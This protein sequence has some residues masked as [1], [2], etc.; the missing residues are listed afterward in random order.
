MSAAKVIPSTGKNPPK[1]M[2]TMIESSSETTK[3]WSDLIRG[4][5]LISAKIGD[6]DKINFTGVQNAGARIYCSLMSPAAIEKYNGG[7]LLGQFSLNADKYFFKSS[8]EYRSPNLVLPTKVIFYRLQRRQNFRLRVPGSFACSLSLKT[9]KSNS[10]TKVHKIWDSSSGGC[11]LMTDPSGPFRMG[12]KITGLLTLG[13]RDP[14]DVDGIVRHVRTEKIDNKAVK[15]IGIEFT[16]IRADLE[17]QLFTTM[18][19]L[20]R[21]YIRS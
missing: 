16:P 15:A 19:E 17:G 3:I 8:W 12:D 5:I 6:S 21:L 4:R 20:S 10:A 11:C 1:E 9:E 7:E 2:F 13:R 14:L 18:M